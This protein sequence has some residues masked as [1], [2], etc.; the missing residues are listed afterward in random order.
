MLRLL[1]VIKNLCVTGLQVK[2][3]TIAMPAY[4]PL[5]KQCRFLKI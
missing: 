3:A 5:F 2:A 1:P 4:W